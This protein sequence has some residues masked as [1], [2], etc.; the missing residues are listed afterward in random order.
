MLVS[1]IGWLHGCR[2]YEELLSA[3]PSDIS[4]ADKVAKKSAE[5][6]A[7]KQL[8]EARQKVQ[9]S[10]IVATLPSFYDSNTFTLGKQPTARLYRDLPALGTY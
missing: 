2:S 4:Q 5:R 3:A 7:A 8:E 9:A 6:E 1:E 10:P